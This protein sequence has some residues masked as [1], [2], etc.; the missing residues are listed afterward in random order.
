MHETLFGSYLYL[1]I[2]TAGGGGNEEEGS[3]GLESAHF[4]TFIVNFFFYRKYGV[5]SAHESVHL[6]MDW[7]CN[8]NQCFCFFAQGSYDNHFFMPVYLVDKQA[9][10]TLQGLIMLMSSGFI[11]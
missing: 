11:V 9:L 8:K 5:T 3:D 7:K 4:P 6:Y 1:Y 2:S 10:S